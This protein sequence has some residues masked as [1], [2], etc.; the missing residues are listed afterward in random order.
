M[1]LLTGFLTQLSRSLIKLR[2]CVLPLI[3][4]WILAALK[5]RGHHN[6]VILSLELADGIDELVRQ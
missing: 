4:R 6:H 1:N 3:S 2:V 5:S